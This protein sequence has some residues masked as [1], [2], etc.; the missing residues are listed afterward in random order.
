MSYCRGCKAEIIWVVTKKGKHTPIDAKPERRYI[1]R[2][3]IKN[4]RGNDVPLVELE[5]T[6]MPHHATCP[7]VD[8]FRKPK[9][10]KNEDNQST[11]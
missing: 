8:R 10:N 4:D 3:T 1:I 7:M 9:E 2:Q 11:E 6:Y 5:K